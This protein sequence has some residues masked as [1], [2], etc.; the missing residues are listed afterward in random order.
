MICKAK[1][2]KSRSQCAEALEKNALRVHSE[3]TRAAA[4]RDGAASTDLVLADDVR[5]H[6][7]RTCLETTVRVRL[8]A[9]SRH[10]PVGCLFGV[11]DDQREVVK[12][13]VLAASL[14]L[15]RTFVLL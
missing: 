3:K 8:E 7:T 10:I 5:G 14:W 2:D 13:A 6:L 11:A 9:E 12:A 1:P 4:E 15:W